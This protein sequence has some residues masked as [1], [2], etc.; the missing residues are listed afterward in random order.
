MDVS[1]FETEPWLR[2]AHHEAGHAVLCDML[3]IRTRRTVVRATGGGFNEYVG[4]SQHSPHD[5]AVTC[6]AGAVAEQMFLDGRNPSYLFRNSGEWRERLS[7]GDAKLLHEAHARLGI[8]EKYLHDFIDRAGKQAA[9]YLARPDVWRNVEQVVGLLKQHGGAIR[10]TS[11]TNAIY[12]SAAP[13]PAPKPAPN[14]SA[15]VGRLA[16]RAAEIWA[17]DGPIEKASFARLFESNAR[18]TA[19]LF[20]AG[21]TDTGSIT[22]GAHRGDDGEK[23]GGARVKI[24]GGKITHG[25]PALAGKTLRGLS[26][27]KP[28]A[29]LRR[30]IDKAH[31]EHGFEKRDI[32]DAIEFVHGERKRTHDERE[33]AK[34]QAR[35]LT[36]LSAGDIS[37]L[38]NSGHDY[39]SGAKAGGLTGQKLAHFDEFAQELARN[40]PELGLG[41]PDDSRADFGRRLWDVL[42]EGKREAP[43][44]HHQDTVDEAVQLLHQNARYAPSVEE[45][46]F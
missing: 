41:D 32:A 15:A 33:A 17:A 40:H 12:E 18:L 2:T 29:E 42:Q 34:E 23:H 22:I 27:T 39:A 10:I 7:A 1:V 4:A 44:K 6:A 20:E 5:F 24:S 35:K 45:V 8:G 3:G 28:H 25:P 21:G 36:G 19:R 13:K 9:C 14:V 16:R 31:K 37:R 43:A 30:A 26:K 38:A 11:G 46:P